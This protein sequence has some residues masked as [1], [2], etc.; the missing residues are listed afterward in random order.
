MLL[1][2]RDPSL[3]GSYYLRTP[4]PYPVL[5]IWSCS[6]VEDMWA[7]SPVSRPTNEIVSCGVVAS[8]LGLL[9]GT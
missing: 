6:E 8:A 4:L 7:A 5:L 1:P 9:Q 2:R 3:W